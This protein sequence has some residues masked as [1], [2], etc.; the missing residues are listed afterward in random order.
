MITHPEEAATHLMNAAQAAAELDELSRG[1]VQMWIN[2]ATLCQPT[3]DLPAAPYGDPHAFG[4]LGTVPWTTACE[5]GALAVAELGDYDAA[6]TLLTSDDQ[7][8]HAGLP[9]QNLY[10][11][12]VEALAGDPASALRNAVALLDAVRRFS[13]AILRGELAVVIGI[14]LLR[15]GQFDRALEHFETAK[16]APMTFP[17]WYA[18]ARRH[19]RHARDHLPPDDAADILTRARSR[20]ADDVL[21]G[22]ATPTST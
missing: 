12:G 20:T 1:F 22:D 13:D 9:V 4:G 16:R 10:R 7:D 5:F 8:V 11:Q 19:G 18:L 17:F 21:T 14:S 3:L 6:V 2:M 15:L